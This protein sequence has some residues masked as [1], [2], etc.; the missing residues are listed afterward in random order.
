[1]APQRVSFSRIFIIGILTLAAI[2]IASAQ[3]ATGSISGRVTVDG[4]PAAGIPVA[5]VAGETVNRRDAAARAVSDSEGHYRVS[6]LAAGQYQV[7]T[8][9]PGKVA[10]PEASPN[11]FP[12]FGSTKNII[13][14]ANED[15]G[16]VDLKLI[17]GGV[18]TGRI[19]NADDKP[20]TEERVSLMLLDANGNPRFG[21]LGSTYDQM[22]QTDD[23]GIY[24]IFGLPPG[25]YKV[26][27]GVDASDGMTRGRRHQKTF[28]PDTSDQSKAT[29]VELKEAGEAGHIDIKVPAARPTY[30][31]SGRVIDTESGL[32]IP[33]A[34]VRFAMVPKDQGRTTPG[35][36]MPADDRGVFTFSGISPGR[37]SAY[38]SSELYGGNFYGSPVYFDLVD[39]DVTGIELKTV[40]GLSVSGVIVSEGL[41]TNELLTMLPGLRVGARGSTPNDQF[42]SGGNSALAPDGSFQIDGLK[43]GRVSISVY[44][45]GVGMIRP[46]IARIEHGGIGISQGFDIQQSVSGLRVVINYGTGAIRGSVKLEGDDR[47]SSAQVYVTCKREGASDGTRA[48]V[49]A[50]G[51]FLIKNLSPGTYEVTVQ[52]RGGNQS[53]GNRPPAP[54]KQIV[55]VTNG[56]ESEVSFVF[57][58]TP[59]PGGP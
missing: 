46:T 53:Q 39:K 52:A 3:A 42:S 50:R 11:Y 8:L 27:V 37:Y 6:G 21:A 18:I 41:P 28:Y 26:S 1:M 15:V 4:K 34:G 33:G 35:W 19:T 23:R 5:A 44:T 36:A 22:Y 59:K 38:A 56:S 48:A 40:P 32:P 45:S 31:V 58:L 43:P 12:Y 24:R 49:D 30:A 17:R 55:N 10:E 14:T 47:A 2:T 16:D 13:L 54:Q 25:R 51:H 29:I 20:V 9:T 7:W 57:D